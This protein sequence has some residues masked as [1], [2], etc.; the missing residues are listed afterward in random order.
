MEPVGSNSI[1]FSRQNS[2]I[3]KPINR[4]KTSLQEEAQRF[5]DA[6]NYSIVKTSFGVGL[7]IPADLS[8]FV[9]I[10]QTKKSGKHTI[11]QTGDRIKVQ[12]RK[13]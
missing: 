3:R 7:L 13:R 10:P 2:P 4:L 1:P 8:E 6:L 12:N 5:S 9:V 11:L